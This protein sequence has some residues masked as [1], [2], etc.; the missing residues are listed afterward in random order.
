MPTQSFAG[1]NLY[2][3]DNL[4]RHEYS[5]CNRIFLLRSDKNFHYYFLFV[6]REIW[7]LK[8]RDFKSS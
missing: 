7:E 5:S 3:K 2:K 6:N 8:I 1:N 4:G